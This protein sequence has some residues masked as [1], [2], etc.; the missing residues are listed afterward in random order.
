MTWPVRVL[1][2]LTAGYGVAVAVR[3]EVLARPCELVEPDGSLT[4]STRILCRAIGLRDAA[5]GTAMLTAPAGA[6]LTWATTV[7]VAADTADAVGFGLTLPSARA[8]RNAALVAGGWAL[9][10]AAAGLRSAA[11]GRRR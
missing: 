8:R 11:S 3:P 9:L 1:G 5:S 4:P 7:R 2:G 6:A 10:T